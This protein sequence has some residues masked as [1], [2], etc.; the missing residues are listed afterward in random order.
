MCISGPKPAIL[1]V[2]LF[3]SGG[4]SKTDE[5]GSEFYITSSV[6]QRISERKLPVKEVSLVSTIKFT[7]Q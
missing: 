3:R 4:L 1:I 5:N 6:L 7:K 2:N